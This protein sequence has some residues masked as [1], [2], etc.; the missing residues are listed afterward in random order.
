M[1]LRRLLTPLI[2]AALIALIVLWQVRAGRAPKPVTIGQVIEGP[3]EV[4]WSAVGY[5]ESLSASVGAPA[6]G[7]VEQVLVEEG[8]RV[9]GGELLA[10]LRDVAESS[11]VSAAAAGADVAASQSASSRA[12]LGEAEAGQQSRERRAR[13]EVE[14]ARTREAQ[15]AGALARARGT[16][17]AA[18]DAARAELDAA[19]ATLQDLERGG[20]PEDIARADAAVRASDAAVTLAAS[21]L[22]RFEQLEASGAAT[23]R[24]VETA[25]EAHTR[26]QASAQA[27]HEAAALARQGARADQIAAARAKVRAA[28]AQVRAAEADLAALKVDEERVE[29][30]RAGRRAAE[31]ALAEV[32][33]GRSR[34]RAMQA[35]LK[36]SR[37]RVAQSR[38][39]ITQ[40]GAQ[41]AD[42]RIRAPFAGIV[43]RR[44]VDPGD[45][46]TPAQPLFS[47]VQGGP[48]WVMAEVDEQDL[49]PVR[50]GQHVVVTAPAYVGR[51]FRGRV[52]RIGGEAVPQTEIRT[53]ARIVRVRVA[54]LP[55]TAAEGDMLKPGME[56]HVN[57]RTT[58]ALKALLIPSDAV[59]PSNSVQTAWAVR[60]GRAVRR[61]I[62]CG[63]AGP[64]QTEVLRGLSAGDRVV[65]SGKENLTDGVRV[66]AAPQPKP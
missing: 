35:D 8:T 61:E 62:E 22:A 23:R 38:A 57:G 34:I 60:G 64:K 63:Y 17:A 46:A 11:A 24:D 58:L 6:M 28:E 39:L 33:A 42:R 47:V 48:R 51:Q 27:A 18:S 3:L 56:V 26:A 55:A 19:R 13:M 54:L 44:F 41:L 32:V 2:F 50:L 7:R 65:V 49:A 12:L 25:R 59:T 31:A 20:R 16:R 5:V 53:G 66:V 9:A 29:E 4:E 36:A 1:K 45:M 43:G 14:A 52:E 30:A 21:E 37:Q 10:V 15:A 40:S